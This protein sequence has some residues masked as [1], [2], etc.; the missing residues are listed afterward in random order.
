M[1]TK[2]ELKI[3]KNVPPPPLNAD[4]STVLIDVCEHEYITTQRLEA[5]NTLMTWFFVQLSTAMSWA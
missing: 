4:D 2:L 5:K 3:L 1:T